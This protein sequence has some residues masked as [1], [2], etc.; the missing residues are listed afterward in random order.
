MITNENIDGGKAFDWGRTS[1][2]YAKY[3]DV[4]P[5]EFYQKIIDMGLCVKGQKVL[6]LGTGTGVLPRNLYSF[7]A[8]FIG[9]DISDNQI[10]KAKE[11]SEKSGMD[12]EF[13][14]SS[15]E[16][17]SFPA[18]SF[19]VVTACQCF[20]YFDKAVVLPKIHQLLKPD[21]HFSVLSLIWLP[22]EDAIAAE[23]EKLVL[24]YNSVWTG[25]G[26]ERIELFEPEWAKPLFRL[27]NAA[28]FDVK[29]PFTRETWHGRIKACRGIGASS[30]SNEAIAEFEREH[31]S[32][33]GRFP[34][35][36]EILHY[37]TILDFQKL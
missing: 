5:E 3:R 23:S 9:A 33:L 12:I 36:F 2:D 19:D 10:K 13:I 17:I 21:G 35:K 14:L 22:Y 31:I 34:E 30:L 37:A 27:S 15:A 11:L 25:A 18:E 4:Y 8:S 6:D 20:I 1:D 26:F 29:V 28:A 32:M 16:D 7:G 24:K